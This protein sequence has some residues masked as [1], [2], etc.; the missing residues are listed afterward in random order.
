MQSLRTT[1]NA[2]EFETRLR[3]LRNTRTLLDAIDIAEISALRDRIDECDE[4]ARIIIS[5]MDVNST[6]QCVA[7]SVENALLAL[8]HFATERGEIYDSTTTNDGSVDGWGWDPDCDSED[9]MSWRVTIRI[10]GGA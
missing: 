10:G 6:A 3:A 2:R 4:I 7:S 8:D 5:A 9:S 1:S